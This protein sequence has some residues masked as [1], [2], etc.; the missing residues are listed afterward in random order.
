MS[1]NLA[2]PLLTKKLQCLLEIQ[3]SP[4]DFSSDTDCFISCQTFL[5]DCPIGFLKVLPLVLI[6]VGCDFSFLSLSFFISSAILSEF[7]LSSNK[8]KNGV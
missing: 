4:K 7:F 2:F 5:S 1:L 3:A 6:F 8:R